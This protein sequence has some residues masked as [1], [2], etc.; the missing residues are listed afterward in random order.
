MNANRHAK[1]H[2]DEQ[3]TGPDDERIAEFATAVE[4]CLERRDDIQPVLADIRQRSLRDEPAQERLDDL[5]TAEPALVT[6][7]SAALRDD[8]EDLLSA[9]EASAA[10]SETEV[11]AFETFWSRN[12][13]LTE[14]VE[15]RLRG[16][17]HD[18]TYWTARGQSCRRRNGLLYVRHRADWGLDEV[19]DVEAPLDAAWN[20]LLTRLRLLLDELGGADVELTD[21]EVKLL[22]KGRPLLQQ[23][24]RQL[25]ALA[26]ADEGDEGTGDV[27]GE[28]DADGAVPDPEQSLAD[29]FGDGEAG[30]EDDG[31]DPD[32]S[33]IGFA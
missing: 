20:D 25:A 17:R 4:T 9:A 8:F 12:D 29:L 13:W 11:E 28:E 15:A 14:G 5:L 3:S 33:L 32:E 30:D 31:D 18:S 26:A 23:F 27:E 2:M 24:D 6:V 10:L 16:R 1:P 19:H 22:V 21:E 7:G